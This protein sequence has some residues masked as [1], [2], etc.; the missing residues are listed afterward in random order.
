MASVTFASVPEISEAVLRS[1]D[2]FRDGFLHAEPFKHVV[3]EDF[4]EPSFAEKLLADFPSF[5]PKLATNEFGQTGRKAVNTKIRTISPAYQDLYRLISAKPFLDLVSRLSGIP[6]LVLDPKMYGGGTHDNQHGQELDPHVDFNYDEAQK[7]HRRL[8]LIVYLNK[9]WRSEWGGA[10]EIHSDPRDPAANRVT[11]Y[12][13]LFNRC[14]LFETNERSWHGFPRIDIPVDKRHLSR[15]SI[16][17]YL[18]TKDRPANEIAPMHSTFYVQRRLP[19]HMQVGYTLT[20]QDLEEVQQLLTVRDGWI[21]TYQ[22]M[23]IEK[24]REIADKCHVIQDLRSH[25]LAPLTGYI[26][27]D[28]PA[29]GIFGDGWVASQAR[30]RIQ[31]LLPV[32]RVALRGYRP[33][34]AVAG[35]V[36]MAIDELTVAESEVNTSTFEVGA[37]FP[38]PLTGTFSLQVTFEP[39]GDRHRIDGDDRDLAF[40]IVE[41]RATHPEVQTNTDRLT[42]ELAQCMAHLQAAERTIEERTA[43]ARR[44]ADEAEA[45]AKHVQALW[46]TFWVRLGGKLGLLP[47]LGKTQ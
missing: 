14:V 8:N 11:S 10:L 23:E 4:F 45:L 28:G 20:H 34:L 7:L 21:K 5:D 3:I 30:L 26:L 35:R 16:S 31:A 39:A 46:S 15:K 12:D 44:N 25:A 9:Q 13:P 27:Q 32:I 29:V 19:R 18:Y 40:V 36:R 22:R 17:I 42:A 1:A 24:N 47:K 6:D 2:T 41:L 37:E 33:E 38:T 43:W